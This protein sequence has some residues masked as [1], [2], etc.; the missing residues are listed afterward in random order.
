MPLP[1]HHVIDVEPSESIREAG[2]R[3]AAESTLAEHPQDQLTLAGHEQDQH[4]QDSTVE[5]TVES[6]LAEILQDWLTL[7]RHEQDQHGQDSAVENNVESTLAENLQHWLTLVRHE[8]DQHGQDSAIENNVDPARDGDPPTSSMHDARKSDLMRSCSEISES[9]SHR[10]GF[11]KEILERC[12]WCKKKLHRDTDL[13]RYGFN[14]GVYC[15][16]EC[17]KSQMLMGGYHKEDHAG[18]RNLH[19]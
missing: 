11:P 4:G 19:L 15:S 12:S 9:H 17:W 6:T 2:T 1:R 13:Y 3:P 18:Q 5:N 14:L 16:V 10:V 8:Q 7:L